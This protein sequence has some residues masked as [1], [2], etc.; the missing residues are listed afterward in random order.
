MQSVK[1]C[2]GKFKQVPSHKDEWPACF[3]P[4][5]RLLVPIRSA[6]WVPELAWMLWQRE[7]S[8]PDGHQTMVIQPL[9]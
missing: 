3:T 9:A 4:E 1:Y 7:E 6:G 5:E 8:Y 2:V